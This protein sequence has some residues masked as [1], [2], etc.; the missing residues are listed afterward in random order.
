MQNLGHT[1]KSMCGMKD[2]QNLPRAD[3]SSMSGSQKRNLSKFFVHAK[4]EHV[5]FLH[6]RVFIKIPIIFARRDR[7]MFSTLLVKAAA[8]TDYGVTV[9]S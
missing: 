6:S 8:K 5:K 2:K 3:N 7:T 1:K 9:F 4:I